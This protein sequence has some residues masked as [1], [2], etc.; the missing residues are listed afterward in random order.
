MNINQRTKFTWNWTVDDPTNITVSMFDFDSI[1]PECLTD[2]NEMVA[3]E[4]D[5]AFIRHPSV[6]GGSISLRASKMGKFYL[7]GYPVDPANDDLAS[8]A[9]VI[10]KSP[11]FLAVLFGAQ[12]DGSA[13]STAIS[14]SGTDTP[15]SAPNNT[16]TPGSNSS[17]TSKTPLIA[18]I[19]GGSGGLFIIL[20]IL[21]FL[22]CR[23]RRKQKEVWLPTPPITPGPFQYESSESMANLRVTIPGSLGVSSISPIIGQSPL[24]GRAKQETQETS[25][26]TPVREQGST[27]RDQPGS[28]SESQP[29]LDLTSPVS[30]VLIHRDSGW[31]PG[32]HNVAWT[33]EMP[34]DYE[35]AR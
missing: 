31:R 34:P 19:I 14:I 2:P 16:A 3:K 33:E 26:S 7:C 23:R 22:C 13:E 20:P 32:T 1:G 5:G 28:L 18:G 21:F 30:R 29:E 24:S 35:S 12:T 25:I 15:M 17:A 10:F 27:I 8:N 6:H 4:E 11:A 9:T